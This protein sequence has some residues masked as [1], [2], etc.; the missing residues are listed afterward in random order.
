MMTKP[1]IEFTVIPPASEGGSE[2]MATIA[3]RVTGQRPGQRIVLF[4][5]SGVMW[6]VQPF[7]DR[8]FTLIQPDS[9]WKS[10]THL[11]TE[12]A[13]LLVEAA[14]RPAATVNA[15]PAASAVVIAEASV[16]GKGKPVVAETKK[17]QFSGYEWN[18]RNLVSERGGAPNYFDPANAWV[19]NAGFLH[20]RLIREADGWTC[21]EVNLTR[22]LGY[23]SYLF[24]VRDISQLEPAAAFTMFTWD[25]SDAAE[26]HREMDIEISRW[27]NPMSKNAQYLVQP[28]YVPA[29]VFRFAAVSGPVTFSFRWEPGQVAFKTFRGRT[30]DTALSPISEHVF[31]SGAP[32][33]RDEKVYINFYIFHYSKTPIQNTNEVVVEKFEYLP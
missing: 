29:N 3:G 5:R 15:L 31:T 28:Y 32:T 2:R 20:L 22:S 11:G 14:Y 21:A 16:K 10:P 7:T 24:I 18:V 1:S 33:P 23:G 12:Y 19:D 13:A 4:A 8:P 27:G 26:H 6:W 17:I 9:T 25:D 30:S